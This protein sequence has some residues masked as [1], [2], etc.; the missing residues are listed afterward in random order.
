MYSICAEHFRLNTYKK[1]YNEKEIKY[2]IFS[3]FTFSNR[4]FSYSNLCQQFPDQLIGN[5]WLHQM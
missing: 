1:Y 3:R 4:R 5:V 2:S